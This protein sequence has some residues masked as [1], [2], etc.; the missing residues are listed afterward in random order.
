MKKPE[1]CT[2]IQD[3]RDAVN[4]YDRQIIALLGERTKYVYEAVRFKT[5]ES[6]IRA[7]G[8]IPALL[9]ERRKWAKQCGVD[10]DFIEKL[11]RMLT[12]HSF[13]VQVKLWK[14]ERRA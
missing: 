11:Y 6:D 10:A 2:G 14:K 5:S 8:H 3:I 9:Q 1:E 7:P 12:D 13:D 4:E